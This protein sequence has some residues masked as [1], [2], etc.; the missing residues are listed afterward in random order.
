MFKEHS[1]QNVVMNKE[2]ILLKT[3]PD[4]KKKYVVLNAIEN[5]LRVEQHSHIQQ[6]SL[7]QSACVI[8]IHCAWEQFCRQ[9]IIISASKQPLTANGIVVKRVFKNAKLTIAKVKSFHSRGYEPKWYNP[10][11]CISTATRINISN[12]GSVTSGLSITN[13]SP[14]PD[15]LNDFR[16]FFAHHNHG[17]MEKIRQDIFLPMNIAMS[18]TPLSFLNTRD[19][20]N[21]F[22]LEVW[23]ERLLIMAKNCIQ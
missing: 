11:D 15:Y 12:L 13:S 1:P 5:S 19:A 9:L 2:G 22:T 4:A 20:N 10:R 16:N 17:I 8:Y 3:K 18:V 14:I 7:I 23:V 6:V 21:K